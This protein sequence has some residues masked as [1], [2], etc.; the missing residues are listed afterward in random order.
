MAY[1]TPDRVLETS[2][3]TGTGALTLLGALSA[4]WQTFSSAVGNANTC[5]YLITAV[6]ED[7]NPTGE[8]ECG[9]G[10]Y[11]TSGN[12]LTRTTVTSSSNAGSAVSFSAGTKRVAV[13]LHDRVLS[14]GMLPRGKRV[15]ATGSTL[16]ESDRGSFFVC[17]AA[18]TFTMPS[19]LVEYWS[20]RFAML[21]DANLTLSSSSKFIHRGNA[22]ASSIAFS[23]ASQ[24]IGSHA[25]V[26]CIDVDGAG[27]LKYIVSNLGGTTATIS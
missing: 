5:P 22:T 19:T 13:G 11:A 10:T 17:T 23:T 7:G 16:F 14:S 18:A 2:T 1:K 12:T 6:N 8:W 15:V 27:T 9:I 24:K 3:T 20:C 4:A 25:L 26:E 21:A